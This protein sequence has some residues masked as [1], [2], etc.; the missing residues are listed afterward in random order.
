MRDRRVQPGADALG[1]EDRVEHLAGRRIEAEGHV[2]QAER[3]L[4][5]RPA[6]LDLAD[7]LDRLQGV[8]PGLLLAGGD[9][10]GQAVDQD[11]LDPHPPAAGQVGDQPLGDAHLPVGGPC[12]P[13]LVDGQRD[14]GRPVL[15]D[16]RHDPGE[17][18]VRAVAVLVVD[19]VDQSAPAE[20]L[21]AGL[22]H[23]G[24]GRVQDDWQRARRRQPARHHAHV[25]DA[26]AADVVHAEVEEVGPLAALLAGD[27][28]AVIEPPLE[29]RLAEGLGA[30]GVR[31]LADG[32]VRGVLAERHMHV[33]RRR[34]RL[35]A[36]AARPQL[37]PADPLDDLAQVLGGGPAAAA[38]EGQ[39]VV[40]Y[41]RLVGV[42]ELG[43]GER[44]GRAVGPEHG[45]ASVGHAGQPDPGVPGQ[46]AQ[47]LGHL[48]G[49]GRAV[50]PD[51]V[52]AER[53]EGAQRRPDLGAQQHRSGGLDGD[54]GDD[55]QVRPG[56]R[57]RAPGAHD[58][59]LGLEEVLRRLDEERVGAAGDQPGRLRLVRVAQVGVRRVAEGGQ[60]GARS[61][62][63]QDVPGVLR[64]G[65]AVGRLAGDPGAGECQLVDALADAVL[66]QVRQV[67]PEGVRLHGVAADREVGVVDVG[68]HVGAG[69]VEDLVAALVPLEVVQA[70]GPG[71]AAWCPWRRRRPRPARRGRCAAR[72]GPGSGGGTT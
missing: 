39:P 32:E 15:D 22:Q 60:P 21:K 4:H 48:G 42:G 28:D 68:D 53:L 34:A 46:V 25:L 70:R 33:Q 36:G 8:A 47:V 6:R 26:V 27:L 23:R 14:D 5:V 11:V 71:P 19:R 40:A 65:P 31:P 72:S 55:G 59:G 58:R 2:G 37:A 12:L 29:H 3:G 52:D 63:P 41:E 44:V 17:P 64:G 62:R 43:R 16:K 18:R 45:Q 61:H 9:R 13:L 50:Q 1:E 35:G 54:L 10:E 30:V 49:A 51:Q 38:G 57:Q 67:G 66:S 20:L 69:G 7:R 56:G 24:L